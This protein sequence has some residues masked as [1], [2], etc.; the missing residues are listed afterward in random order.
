[1]KTG[2]R[3]STTG[4]KPLAENTTIKATSWSSTTLSE[5]ITPPNPAVS[6]ALLVNFSPWLSCPALGTL[7][8]AAKVA[9]DISSSQIS[10][11][12]AVVVDPQI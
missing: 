2:K 4:T 8:P 11:S 9:P 7:G 3:R 10:R 6:P 5:P 1:M 12:M